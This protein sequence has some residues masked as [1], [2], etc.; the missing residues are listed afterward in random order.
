MHMNIKE[1]VY[2]NKLHNETRHCYT[3]TDAGF[4]ALKPQL[5]QTMVEGLNKYLVFIQW[6]N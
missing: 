2:W 6:Y 4:M 3:I 1:V 5:A